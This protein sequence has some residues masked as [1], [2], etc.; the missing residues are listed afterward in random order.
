MTLRETCEKSTLTE[1]SMQRSLKKIQGALLLAGALLGGAL[2]GSAGASAS[3][4]RDGA[5]VYEKICRHCHEMGVGPAIKGRQL[6][7]QYIERVV[8]FGN[9]AMP[10]FRPSE[11][12]DAALGEVARLIGDSGAVAGS[13]VR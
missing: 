1:E 11:I 2:P 12:D 5:Q 13:Q 7:T 4:W 9:R 10:S 6:P 3:Q 8:R